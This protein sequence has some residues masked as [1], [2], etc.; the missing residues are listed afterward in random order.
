MA[1]VPGDLKAVRPNNHGYC[2]QFERNAFL[3]LRVKWLMLFG[4]IRWQFIT[5]STTGSIVA[6]HFPNL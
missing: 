2:E 6:R 1:I 5:K 3:A 4:G